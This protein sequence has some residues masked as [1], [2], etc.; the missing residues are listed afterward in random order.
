LFKI[1]KSTTIAEFTFASLTLPN[2]NLQILPTPK[3][4]L[5]IQVI[6]KIMKEELG[7]WSF[8]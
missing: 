7:V 2:E 1:A 5:I 6:L 8:I 4:H 3:F